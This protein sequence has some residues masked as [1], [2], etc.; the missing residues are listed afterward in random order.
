MAKSLAEYILEFAKQARNQLTA[1]VAKKNNSEVKN[2]T[3]QGY[4]ADGKPLVKDRDQTKTARGL[5]NVSQTKGSKLI[6]DSQ[7]TVE[8]KRKAPKKDTTKGR[9]IVRK[10]LRELSNPRFLLE[11]LELFLDQISVIGDFILASNSH[12][13]GYGFPQNRFEWGLSAPGSATYSGNNINRAKFSYTSPYTSPGEYLPSSA[14]DLVVNNENVYSLSIARTIVRFLNGTTIAP[15]TCTIELGSQSVTVTSPNIGSFAGGDGIIDFGERDK[16]SYA[17]SAQQSSSL[18]ASYIGWG[19]GSTSI[20]LDRNAKRFFSTVDREIYID[21]NFIV[22]NQIVHWRTLHEFRT[23]EISGRE[24]HVYIYSIFYVVAIDEDLHV[25]NVIDSNVG[26]YEEVGAVGKIVPYFVHTRYNVSTGQLDWNKNICS[27]RQGYSS[28]VLNDLN[29]INTFEITNQMRT[30]FPFGAAFGY[31]VDAI[32]VYS[33][34]LTYNIDIISCNYTELFNILDPDPIFTNAY[35]GD[36][37]SRTNIN[38][39][40]WTGS[41]SEWSWILALLKIQYSNGAFKDWETN[42]VLDYPTVSPCQTF[43][44]RNARQ[45]NTWLTGPEGITSLSDV[46][47][48]VSGLTSVDPIQDQID[49][50]SWITTYATDTTVSS[51]PAYDLRRVNKYL[52]PNVVLL[53]PLAPYPVP[54][55]CYENV[56]ATSAMDTYLSKGDLEYHYNAVVLHWEVPLSSYTITSAVV[57]IETLYA[58]FAA[59]GSTVVISGAGYIDGTYTISGINNLTSFYFAVDPVQYPDD[60]PTTEILGTAEIIP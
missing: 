43:N 44:S 12:T 4:D 30:S 32:F 1:E 34:W 52:I 15:S 17:V 60:V 22:S 25:Q 2:V 46:I 16:V 11:P 8:Y 3:W 47:S 37:I 29:G 13:R 27:L 42:A 18:S 48:V 40:G 28:E 57:T 51:I 49:I 31:E 21:L 26:S 23:R 55:A 45:N 19:F 6:Y 39:A 41:S 20:T 24:E 56:Y 53:T 10:A 36:W 7:N 33:K 35:E 38:F 14:T 58:S 59:G 54:T 9:K 50:S 5:G